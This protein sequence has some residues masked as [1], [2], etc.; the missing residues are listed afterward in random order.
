MSTWLITGS[1]SGLGRAFAEE[2]LARG[3]SVVVTARYADTVRDLEEQYPDTALATTLDVATIGRGSQ[4]LPT[5]VPQ[6]W[7]LRKTLG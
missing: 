6:Q 4:R 2:A 3:H 1:S 5:P 7:S